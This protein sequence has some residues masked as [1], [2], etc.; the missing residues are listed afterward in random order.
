MKMVMRVSNTKGRAFLALKKK[1][2]NG[3]K[4]TPWHFNETRDAM[5]GWF[6]GFTIISFT[7]SC[8]F[9]HFKEMF[10]LWYLMVSPEC[11]TVWSIFLWVN[12]NFHAHIIKHA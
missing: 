5:L 6:A 12:T 7:L 10:A 9:P 1:L 2:F 8:L 3:L 11:V 4:D